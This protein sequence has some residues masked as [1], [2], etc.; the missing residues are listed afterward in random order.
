MHYGP[1]CTQFGSKHTPDYIG[2]QQLSMVHKL[3]FSIHTEAYTS[4]HEQGVLAASEGTVV[5]VSLYH[6]A[7][8]HK[9]HVAVLP[10]VACCT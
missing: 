3:P 1:C 6:L 2:V 10:L 9:N 7:S 8:C 4:L 5:Q